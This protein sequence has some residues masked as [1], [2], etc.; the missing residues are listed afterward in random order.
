MNQEMQVKR[1]E[2]EK[3]ELK[4][5]LDLQHQCVEGGPGCQRPGRVSFPRARQA[6]P[7]V[8]LEAVGLKP[9]GACAE[10]DIHLLSM[11]KTQA[12]CPVCALMA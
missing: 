3:Q 8:L 4:E 11:C 6:W 1:L 9:A 2:S 5:Q 10:L 12:R 7:S